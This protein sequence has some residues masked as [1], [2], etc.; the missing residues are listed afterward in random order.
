MILETDTDN[1]R[2]IDVT[3][4]KMLHHSAS[5]PEWNNGETDDNVRDLND[6][7]QTSPVSK[8]TKV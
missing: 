5:N 8:V 1:L 7:Q 3:W 2:I 4:D 6:S